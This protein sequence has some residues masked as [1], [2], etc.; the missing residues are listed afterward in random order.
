MTAERAVPV[1]LYVGEWCFLI[2]YRP[3]GTTPRQRIRIFEKL[4]RILVGKFSKIGKSVMQNCF[5]SCARCVIFCIF[6]Q[7]KIYIKKIQNY[8]DAFMPLV[9]CNFIACTPAQAITGVNYWV[10]RTRVCPWLIAFLCIFH[11]S[12][13]LIWGLLRG[14]DACMPPTNHIS[15]HVSHPRQMRYFCMGCDAC[16]C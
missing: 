9:N 12:R 2:I 6:S 1:D 10:V 3:Y 8:M 11:S 5:F 13:N 14:T 7:P 4:L 15:L 16:S